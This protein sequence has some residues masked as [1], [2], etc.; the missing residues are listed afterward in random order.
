MTCL[1]LRLLVF[2]LCMLLVC[3]RVSVCARVSV[4]GRVCTEETEEE[5]TV[6]RRCWI[7]ICA[8]VWCVVCDE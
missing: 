2:R 4:C 5:E 1:S 6:N 8:R 7:S 3:G